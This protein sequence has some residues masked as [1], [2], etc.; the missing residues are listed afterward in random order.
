M[1]NYEPVVALLVR[2]DGRLGPLNDL[3]FSQ[4]VEVVRT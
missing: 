4:P 1:H 3:W 2:N